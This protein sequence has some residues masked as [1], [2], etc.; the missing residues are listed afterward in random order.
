MP[1][2]EQSNLEKTLDLVSEKAEALPDSS[3]KGK[4][5]IDESLL[6]VYERAIMAFEEQVNNAAVVE[7]RFAA[8]NMEVAKM[9]LDSA[10]E[11]LKLRHRQTE[12][13]DKVK[14]AQDKIGKL[15]GRV[16]QNNLIVADRNDIL[17]RIIENS[18][19]RKKRVVEIE[20]EEE[21]VMD[22]EFEISQEE[23]NET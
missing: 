10:M 5:K 8:R 6:D 3:P 23:K 12:H 17:K 18:P 9:F 11:A 19:P 1:D 20:E 21:L 14:I 15:P 22:S 7:P 4:L 16:T 13:K 2:L